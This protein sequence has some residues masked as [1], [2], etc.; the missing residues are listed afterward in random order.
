[1]KDL[2]Q[3][4]AHETEAPSVIVLE[5]CFK[6]T[7]LISSQ[8]QKRLKMFPYGKINSFWT[9]ERKGLLG[10]MRHLVPCKEWGSQ[11]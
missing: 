6:K 7:S 3:S 10:R 2:R 11:E 1:M 5:A 9:S 4:V 8:K